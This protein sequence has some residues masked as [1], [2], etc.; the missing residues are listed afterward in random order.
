MNMVWFSKIQG[1]KFGAF[2]RATVYNIAMHHEWLW[3]IRDQSIVCHISKS[4]QLNYN[5]V[6]IKL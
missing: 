1:E 4:S 5:Y 3:F 2:F 6:A